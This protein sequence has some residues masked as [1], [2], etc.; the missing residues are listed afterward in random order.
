MFKVNE[1]TC[2][3]KGRGVRRLLMKYIK[4][5]LHILFGIA[6]LLVLWVGS[7]QGYVWLMGGAD[8]MAIVVSSAAMFLG[9]WTALSYWS[10]VFKWDFS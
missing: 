6:I 10:K 5:F 8:N 1:D 3:I 2:T 7:A 9:I 4:N